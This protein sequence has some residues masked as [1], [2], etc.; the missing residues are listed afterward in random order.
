MLKFTPKIKQ[1]LG[2]C[3][4][5]NYSRALYYIDYVQSSPV[6]S[7]PVGNLLVSLIN[8]AKQNNFDYQVSD[9]RD[10]LERPLGDDPKTRITHEQIQQFHNCN[11]DQNSGVKYNEVLREFQTFVRTVFSLSNN[12]L[13]LASKLF[14]NLRLNFKDNWLSF[15]ESGPQSG[16][17]N[18]NPVTL[19]GIKAIAN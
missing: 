3:T 14:P 11:V 4:L 8:Q 6:Q 9:M 18:V 19:F 12:L 15:G 16:V 5:D 10:Y 1:D 2:N 7:S 13:K 17:K